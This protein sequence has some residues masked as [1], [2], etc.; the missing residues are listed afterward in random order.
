MLTAGGRVGVVFNLLMEI[1]EQFIFMNEKKKEDHSGKLINNVARGIAGALPTTALGS[2]SLSF[3]R[4]YR[5][6]CSIK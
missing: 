3:I 4:A 5:E 1:C 2:S 6:V